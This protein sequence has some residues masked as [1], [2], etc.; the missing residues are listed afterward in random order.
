MQSEDSK[1]PGF[2]P[3]DKIN[4]DIICSDCFRIKNYRNINYKNDTCNYDILSN[5]RNLDS[6][7]NQIFIVT[8]IFRILETINNKQI[9]DISNL[10]NCIL[11]VNKI[12]LLDKNNINFPYFKKRLESLISKKNKFKDIKL[13]SAIN[14][15]FSFINNIPQKNIIF[16]GLSSSGKSSIINKLIKQD[17]L[18][19]SDILNTTRDMISIK[20]KD[21]I[22]KD[23]P[24][25]PLE[26]DILNLISFDKYKFFNNLK[27]I[28][29]I[30]YQI[31]KKTSLCIESF[32]RLDLLDD[33][34]CSVNLFIPN[35]ISC[36]RLSIKDIEPKWQKMINEGYFISS[37]NPREYET[38]LYTNKTNIISIFMSGI[39][40]IK[41]NF[42]NKNS[43][44]KINYLK[45]LGVYIEE[46][47][48]I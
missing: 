15:T 3:K 14:N 19:Q 48:V 32:F 9:K 5:I 22:I 17:L 43:N 36:K 45:N 12:D 24:G 35:K 37:G 11:L 18:I 46:E 30:N 4:N 8:D 27:E 13:C 28:K 40:I 33:L 1:K 6:K 29:P 47:W 2:V 26:N 16:C 7:N 10:F 39:G 44:I 20:W 41:L 34:E 38:R 25:I 23:T 21:K 31:K 42:K